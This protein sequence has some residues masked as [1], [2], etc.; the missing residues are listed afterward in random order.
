MFFSCGR[1]ARKSNRWWFKFALSQGVWSLCPND[2]PKVVNV[3][4]GGGGEGLTT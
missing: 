1:R 4:Q 3:V 2:D